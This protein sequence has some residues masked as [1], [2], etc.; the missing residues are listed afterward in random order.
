MFI[1]F[2][3]EAPL[4]FQNGEFLLD[5]RRR[6]NAR[7]Y[8]TEW[9]KK[10]AARLIPE[11]VKFYAGSAGLNVESV[12]ISHGRQRLGSCAGRGRLNFSWRLILAPA[13]VIDYVAA[14]ELA[15]IRE[16]NHSSR[17]WKKVGEI[18]LDYRAAK[19]WIRDYSHLLDI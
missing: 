6:E 17:F 3:L 4:V 19:K 8:F 11:R 2:N 7:R 5:A 15:H 12:T 9:Y 16:R 14:H 1:A 18:Y 10:E 13:Q